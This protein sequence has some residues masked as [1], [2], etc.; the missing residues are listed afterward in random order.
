MR[1]RKRPG[2]AAGAFT[3]IDLLEEAPGGFGD[4]ARIV[5]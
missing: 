2:C 5:N 3:I 4:P 1:I